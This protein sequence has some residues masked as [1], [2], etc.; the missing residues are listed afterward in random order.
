MKTPNRTPVYYANNFSN[1]LI[2]FVAGGIFI[3][4]FIMLLDYYLMSWPLYLNLRENFMAGIFSA[5]MLP[6]MTTYGLFSAATYFLWKKMKKAASLAREEHVLN[7]AE[8][9]LLLS[10]REPAR[11]P[12][13]GH[14]PLQRLGQ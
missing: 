10:P 7:R 5:P 6:M 2:A 4:L 8:Q 12:P 3:H 14:R 13:P 11:D 9:G 1:M